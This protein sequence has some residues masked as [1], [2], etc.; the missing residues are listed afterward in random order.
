MRTNN[1][2]YH[3]TFTLEWGPA[4]IATFTCRLQLPPRLQSPSKK[5]LIV[6]NDHRSPLITIARLYHLLSSQT[7]YSALLF[8]LALHLCTLRFITKRSEDQQRSGE[9]KG[10]EHQR[11]RKTQGE[12]AGE[13]ELTDWEEAGK[14]RREDAA[15]NST[16]L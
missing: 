5:N 9:E 13:E 10:K 6:K 3:H 12:T 15:G 1:L 16:K 2:Y 4:G 7:I 11:Q 8:I 14:E